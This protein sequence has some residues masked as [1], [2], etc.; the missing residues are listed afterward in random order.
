MRVHNDWGNKSRCCCCL[1]RLHRRRRP[2]W[3]MVDYPQRNQ[4]NLLLRENKRGGGETD[5]QTE[6]RRI[7]DE[8]R[9]DIT[10]TQASGAIS[11]TNATHIISENPSKDHIWNQQYIIKGIRF[12]WVW[13]LITATNTCC[14]IPTTD[15]TYI[16]SIHIKKDLHF[17]WRH[18]HARYVLFEFGEWSQPLKQLVPLPPHTPHTSYLVISQ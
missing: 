6:K 18:V 14:S 17:R 9:L 15:S 1:R 8:W 11:S 16:I 10:S 13:F 3:N 12:V 2:C 7:S 5:R 4:I